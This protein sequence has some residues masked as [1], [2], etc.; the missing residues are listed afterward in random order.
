MPIT[1]NNAYV[2]FDSPT[3]FSICIRMSQIF[4]STHHLS[5][6][7]F[8]RVSCSLSGNHHRK[9]LYIQNPISNALLMLGAL[10][11]D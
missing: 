4:H 8:N 7:K 9:Y 10:F 3:K 2:L 6:F 11:Q 5:E 1:C